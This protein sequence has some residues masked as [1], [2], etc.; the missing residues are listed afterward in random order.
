MRVPQ[1]DAEVVHHSAGPQGFVQANATVVQSLRTME[2]GRSSHRRR[3]PNR[4]LHNLF[5]SPRPTSL[6][7]LDLPGIDRRLAGRP[8]TTLP[9]RR[10]EVVFNGVSWSLVLSACASLTAV[11]GCVECRRSCEEK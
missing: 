7:L 9:Q 11:D 10:Y 8:K 4:C 2:K 5:V 6:L 3:R 1:L